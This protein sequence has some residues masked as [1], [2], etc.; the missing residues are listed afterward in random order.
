MTNKRRAFSLMEVM[1]VVAVLAVL[2]AISVP[3]W[4]GM[5]LAV[6]A[7]AGLR[8]GAEEWLLKAV[9][10]FVAPGRLRRSLY[11]VAVILMSAVVFGLTGEIVR[12]ALVANIEPGMTMRDILAHL[13]LVSWF[14]GFVAGLGKALL[15]RVY[16]MFSVQNQLLKVQLQ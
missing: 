7:M 15:A 13:V 2:A 5:G 1:L 6:L 4:I 10:R 8:M 14:C 9:T 3:L 11:A 12:S 16:T